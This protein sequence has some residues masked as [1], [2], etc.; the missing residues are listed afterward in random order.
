MGVIDAGERIYAVEPAAPASAVKDVVNADLVWLEDLR[1][2]LSR[3]RNTL[4]ESVSQTSALTYRIAWATHVH[5]PTDGILRII[6][7]AA[8]LPA[9]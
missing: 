4:Y 9:P 6:P 5:M 8:T 7:N 1:A 3:H 2:R